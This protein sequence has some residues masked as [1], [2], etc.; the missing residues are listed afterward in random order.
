MD[1]T[2]YR[3][4]HKYITTVVNHDTGNV[5]WVAQ[6]HGKTIFE[7]FFKQLTPEQRAS[8]QLVS[9][10]GAKWIDECVREYC[11]NANRCIDPFHVVEWA[12]DALDDVRVETWREAKKNTPSRPKAKPG[13]PK[14]DAPKKDTT[15]NEIKNSKIALGKSTSNLTPNQQAKVEWIAKTEP[16]LYRAYKLKEALR[17]V[18]YNDT[19]EEAAEALTAWVKW[20]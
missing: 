14:K 18:F 4:G 15:A 20:A 11:P 3:K 7:K 2:S 16:R 19:V 1:E 17:L 13:R 9:S 12:M 6:G 10:D 5:I 8:I